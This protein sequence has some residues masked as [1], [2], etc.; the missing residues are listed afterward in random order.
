MN[1]LW[2]AATMVPFLAFGQYEVA[3]GCI[4]PDVTWFA[5]EV[6]FRLAEEADWYVW[7]ETSPERHLVAYRCAHSLFFIGLVMAFFPAV[8]LGWCIHLALDLPTHSGRMQQR[9][10]YPLKWRWPWVIQ[11]SSP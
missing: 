8:A 6:R 2:H 4:I 5:Q 3:I 10:L 11:S 9:P 7:I 1:V